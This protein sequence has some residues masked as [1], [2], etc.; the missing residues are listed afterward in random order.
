MS[1]VTEEFI[2]WF[3][4]RFECLNHIEIFVF[5]FLDELLKAVRVKMTFYLIYILHRTI[6]VFNIFYMC[7]AVQ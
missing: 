4:A 3:M 6:V 1:T 5:E 2:P 7:L